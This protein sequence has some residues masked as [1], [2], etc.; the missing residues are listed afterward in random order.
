[1]RRLLALIPLLALLLSTPTAAQSDCTTPTECAALALQVPVRDRIDLAQRLY[2]VDTL[3]DVPRQPTPYAVGDVATFSI[4]NEA[5]GGIDTF[6]AV[7]VAV[8]EHIALWVDQRA[9]L[10]TARV[11]ALANAFDAE[12]YA[13]T[14]ALWGSEAQPGIDADPRVHALFATGLSPSL[15]A[16]F[17]VEH[18][19]PRAVVPHSNQREMFVVNAEAVRRAEDSPA[20]LSVLA[21]EFQH[22]IRANVARSTAG[23]LDE[24]FS[25]FTMDALGHD[26]SMPWATAADFLAAPETQL[27]TWSLYGNVGAH[28][29]AAFLYVSYLKQRLGRDLLG[30]LS[31]DDTGLYG[32]AS[33]RAVL[34][35]AGLD[36]DSFFADWA[37]A[38]ALMDRSLGDSWGYA[39]CDPLDPARS[40]TVTGLP[41]DLTV[42]LPPYSSAYYDLPITQAG[43][44]KVQL[45]VAESLPLVA[46]PSGVDDPSQVWISARADDSDATLTRTLDLR[47]LE[48]AALRY[49]LYHDLEADWDYGYV[50]LSSDGGLNWTPLSTPHTTTDNPYGTAYGPGY[51]GT[52]GGWL[53]ESL[54][55]DAYLGQ[56][57]LL[58][59]ELIH[60]D[61]VNRQGMLLD[62]LTLWADGTPTPLESGWEARGWLWGVNAVPLRTWVQLIQVTRGGE[63]DVQRVLAAG[64]EIIWTPTI[65]DDAQRVVLALSPMALRSTTPASYVLTIN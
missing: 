31:R 6:D 19:Y 64:P 32:M 20:V 59:F 13:Q 56:Q 22:M 30:T 48:S 42:T 29:G 51:T 39:C 26:R 61:A 49:R 44:L 40:S 57:V 38:N 60:D 17:S 34:A 47:A 62:D 12:V 50:M 11:Q 3:P 41:A 18:S 43:P 7:L 4:S 54:S 52:S 27:N 55:L 10:D 53:E 46:L 5:R 58:R 45:N 2:G 35:D 25:M 14:R 8:G 24:G 33:V 37:A 21:H 9:D 63:V 65:R 1:M 23:W 36:A 28:Y 16:Y 15:I